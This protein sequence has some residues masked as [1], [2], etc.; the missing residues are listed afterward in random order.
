[1]RDRPLAI[2][3]CFECEHLCI[4][5]NEDLLRSRVFMGMR[6]ILCM[7]GEELFSGCFWMLLLYH[8]RVYCCV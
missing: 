7:N 4:K 5:Y 1:M 8:F 6:Y 3:G 2:P